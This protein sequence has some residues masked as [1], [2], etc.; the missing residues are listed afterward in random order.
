MEGKM[1]LKDLN[2]TKITE[3]GDHSGHIKALFKHAV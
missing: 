1:E 3:V 2:R